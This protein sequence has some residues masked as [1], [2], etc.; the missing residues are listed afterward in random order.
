MNSETPIKQLIDAALA[1]IGDTV[2][3]KTVIGEPIE[4]PGDV[5]LIPI[6]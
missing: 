4:L 5:T 2:D 3:M 1:K 6:S